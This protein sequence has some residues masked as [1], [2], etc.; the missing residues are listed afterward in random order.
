MNLF[1]LPEGETSHPRAR[2][3]LEWDLDLN[4]Q[5]RDPSI[6]RKILFGS[7][8]PLHREFANQFGDWQILKRTFMPTLVK[9]P[10]VTF[11]IFLLSTWMVFPSYFHVNSGS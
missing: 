1:P 4:C 6:A 11:V 5:L 2:F 9:Y 7:V 3:F 8:P 10:I